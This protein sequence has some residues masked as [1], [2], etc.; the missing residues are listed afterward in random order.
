MYCE[1]NDETLPPIEIRRVTL[2]RSVIKVSG[3]TSDRSRPAAARGIQ[4]VDVECMRV[5]TDSYDRFAQHARRADAG[6]NPGRAFTA[7]RGGFERI[8]VLHDRHLTDHGVFWK[9]H[10][11][12]GLIRPPN[13]TRPSADGGS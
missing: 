9:V 5:T 10:S 13:P 7:D 2:G 8:A 1:L 6:G 12:D 4:I 11:V 3:E